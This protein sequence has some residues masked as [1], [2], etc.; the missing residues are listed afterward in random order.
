M[1]ARCILYESELDAIGAFD[2][3]EHIKEDEDVLHQ[4]Y[5]A[6]RPGGFVFIAVPQ[7][8][9]LWSPVDVYACHVRRYD[10]SEL[11]NKV[12]KEGFEIIRST[13]FVST[14]LPVMYVSRFLQ[15]NKTDMDI[16]DMVELHVN[17][18]L[19]RIFEWFLSFELALIRLGVSFPVGGSRM[20]VARKPT[21]I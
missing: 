7:H 17:P 16:D 12:H 9:W 14:L 5:K 1:D 8:R 3:L 20:L 11:Y 10:A 6:L 19:N 13:S 4:M 21:V 2:V 15:R 18:I